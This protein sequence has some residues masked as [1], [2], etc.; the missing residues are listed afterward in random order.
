VHA[1]AQLLEDVKEDCS[2]AQCRNGWNRRT[3]FY[4]LLQAETSDPSGNWTV[5]EVSN[6]RQS[7]YL[8]SI[9]NSLEIGK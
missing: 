7:T 5:P 3:A 6:G 1:A 9:I 8:G 2:A 4:E